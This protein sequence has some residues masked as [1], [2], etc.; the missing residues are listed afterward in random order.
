MEKAGVPLTPGYHGDNQEPDLLKQEADRIGY[1][2]LIKAAA[3][4]GGKGMRAVDR[5]RTSSRRWPRASARRSRASATS[6]C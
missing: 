4:G 3:G 1:P 2:V 6:T 5:A